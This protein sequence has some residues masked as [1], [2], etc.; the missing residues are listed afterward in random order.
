M[1][2]RHGN[3]VDADTWRQRHHKTAWI[4]FR[5]YSS[6]SRSC[7]LGPLKSRRR[8]AYYCI[9]APF[10]RYCRFWRSWPHPYSTQMNPAK[11]E[12]LWAGSKHNITMLRS[13]APALQLGSDTVTASD[14]VRVLGVTI[15]SDL[16]LEKHVSKTCAACF[17]WLYQLRRIRKSLADESAA[18]LVHA[19]VTSRID[20]CNALMQGR[21]RRSPTSCNECNKKLSYRRETARQLCMST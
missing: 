4:T 9:L 21:R 15:S 17:Y 19:Y 10:Q 13:H 2:P 20:Y 1:Y 7:I 12:L 16:S 11:T 14:H 6:I 5:G 8:T 18:T 3:L